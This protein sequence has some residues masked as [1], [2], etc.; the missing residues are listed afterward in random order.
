MSS[1][2]LIL[3]C[4][5]FIHKNPNRQREIDFCLNRNIENKA[6]DKI[7]LLNEK[8]YQYPPFIL[9]DKV[10]QIEIS[11]RLSYYDFFNFIIH[12]S[13]SKENISNDDFVM[14]C[15]ADIFF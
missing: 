8:H 3:I 14:L 7:V 15:N 2:S 9:N 1:S 13:F 12:S 5:Y 11:K 6:I 4:Q 10:K